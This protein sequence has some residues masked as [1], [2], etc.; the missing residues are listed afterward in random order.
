[1]QS[2]DAQDKS[3]LYLRDAKVAGEVQTKL[4]INVV[5]A[6]QKLLSLRFENLSVANQLVSRPATKT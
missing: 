5:T 2:Q 4:R 3:L 1:M 6:V